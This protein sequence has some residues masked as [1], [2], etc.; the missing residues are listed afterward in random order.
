MYKYLNPTPHPPPG[1]AGKM[2]Q[3]VP[4][5]LSQDHTAVLSAAGTDA[6]T[7]V[8]LL[9]TRLGWH[10]SRAVAALEFLVDEGMAWVDLQVLSYGGHGVGGFVGEGRER[11]QVTS[12]SRYTPPYSGL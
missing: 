1:R 7:S 2:V 4:V 3:S 8:A 10:E 11:E 5:E 12:P 6:F 9:Q